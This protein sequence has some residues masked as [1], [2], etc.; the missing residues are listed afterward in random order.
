MFRSLRLQG[1][2]GPLRVQT[3]EEGP[4]VLVAALTQQQMPLQQ[5]SHQH[6]Q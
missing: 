4:A 2:L 5:L 3:I 1:Q 6:L